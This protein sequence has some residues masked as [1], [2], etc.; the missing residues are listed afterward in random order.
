MCRT[1]FLK[2]KKK[3]SRF[4]LGIAFDITEQKHFEEQL[5]KEKE[6]AEES[7]R[8]KTTF[9]SNI[10]HEIRT[11]MNAIIGF[12]ELINIGDISSENKKEYLTIVKN[13]SKH[14][15]SLI[16]DIT[17][18]SKFESGE[19][20]INNSET[21]LVKLFNEL[22][23]EYNKELQTRKKQNIELFLKLP[24]AKEISSIYTDPGR[25]IR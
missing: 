22:Y 1:L 5:A 19:I 12:N 14:L 2:E 11:P 10:S 9:L 17:E 3:G 25:I 20:T 16:D 13:K 24:V 21:N 23:E 8:I 7:N 4:I 6:K 15:L 18:L